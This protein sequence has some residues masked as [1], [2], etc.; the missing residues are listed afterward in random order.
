[1]SSLCRL[2]SRKFLKLR[3]FVGDPNIRGGDAALARYAARLLPELVFT[4]IEP[5]PSDSELDRLPTK[6]AG[7]AKNDVL[8]ADRPCR[9]LR[10]TEE[11]PADR[12]PEGGFPRSPAGGTGCVVRPCVTLDALCNGR[13]VPPFV[14]FAPFAPS[15][16]PRNE[17][18]PEESESREVSPP[19]GKEPGTTERHGSRSPTATPPSR[20]PPPTVVRSCPPFTPVTG[21]IAGNPARG[22]FGG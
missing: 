18:R 9:G 19:T 4:G 12:F 22:G 14:P 7:D 13:R 5:S 11:E 10:K 17:S 16:N 8:D 20:S 1:M 15:A 3:C 2:R 6:P 21:S